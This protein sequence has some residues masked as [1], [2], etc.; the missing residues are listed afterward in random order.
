MKKLIK[1][2]R[3]SSKKA[4]IKLR[5]KWD[6]Y[7]SPIEKYFKVT[8]LFLKHISWSSKKRLCQG[9]FPRW[10]FSLPQSLTQTLYLKT[11]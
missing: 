4:F 10:A 3:L 11:L 5:D 8:N 1:L 2:I 6:I 9:L 7:C